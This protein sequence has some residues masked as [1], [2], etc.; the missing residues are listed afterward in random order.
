MKH[1]FTAMLG[2]LAALLIFTFGGLLL[3]AGLVGAIVSLGNQKLSPAASLEKGS[4]LVFDLSTNLTDSPPTFDWGSLMT[5]SSADRD[6]TLQLRTVTRAIREA[7]ADPRIAG[8]LIKGSLRPAGYGSGY[9]AL[10]EVRMALLDFRAS[11]KPLRAYLDQVATRDYYLTS[12]ASD[13][14]LDP[15]GAIEMPGLASESPYFAGLFQ[16]YGVDV[17]VTREG[18]YKSAVEPLTRRDM[19]PESREETQKLLDDIWG[20]VLADIAASRGLTV[21]A[22]QRTVDAEGLILAPAARQARWVDRVADRD[23]VVE[24]LRTETGTGSGEESFKQV[25]LPAYA[26]IG[27]DPASRPSAGRGA[28]AVV[29]AEGEIVDGDGHRRRGGRRQ[30][31]RRNCENCAGTTT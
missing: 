20:S 30:V 17:Q 21:A 1:F 8:L 9:A 14:A 10:R 18:K 12:A 16:K 22:I 19:S 15:Y 31:R 25:S 27:A 29:Y 2:A 4:Y 6:S 7:A 3:F 5:A 23:Q 13:V 28:V 11:G 24:G 26:K